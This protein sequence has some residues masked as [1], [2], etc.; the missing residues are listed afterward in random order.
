MALHATTR[1]AIPMPICGQRP[2]MTASR[3][4][5]IKEFISQDNDKDRCEKC[6]AKLKRKGLM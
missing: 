6:I 3:W 1:K 2:S 4:A 5:S